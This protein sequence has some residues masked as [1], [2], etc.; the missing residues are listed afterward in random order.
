VAARL[1]EQRNLVPGKYRGVAV[2]QVDVPLDPSSLTRHFIGREAYRRTRFVVVRNG[3]GTAIVR[4]ARQ[5]DEPLFAPITEVELLAGADE[6]AYVHCSDIDTGVP[7]ALAAAA[8]SA[9]P[10]ARA[11]VVQGRYEHV[12]FIVDPSPL[13][14]TVREVA[15][16]QPPKL[17]DQAQRILDVTETLPP[18]Q[19]VPDVVRLADLVDSVNSAESAA[20]RAAERY[21]VP[22]R[23]SGF[24]PPG[25]QTAYLDERPPHEPWTLVGCERSQQIHEWFYGGRAD[26]VDI[27]PRARSPIAGPLLT[28]C[29]LF[30]QGIVLDDGQVTVPWGASLAQVTE[31]LVGLAESW[32]PAWAPA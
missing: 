21:L 7:S 23:G 30:E 9:A 15:P 4:V 6:C 14:V 32:E 18:M 1:S 5:T 12:N 28:K 16:P 26:Q 27:C 17:L 2:A 10:G 24:D 19:L 3:A 11:V 20:Q 8:L 22:C 31:A 29:C 25:A 13:R